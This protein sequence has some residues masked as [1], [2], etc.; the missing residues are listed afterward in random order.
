M[1]QCGV[2][3]P[4]DWSVWLS[5]GPRS[6][7]G[8]QHR[9]RLPPRASA[10]VVCAFCAIR[11]RDLCSLRYRPEGDA[12]CRRHHSIGASYAQVELTQQRISTEP[13]EGAAPHHLPFG[14]D[15]MTVGNAAQGGDMLI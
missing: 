6:A 13:L 5:R 1:S 14:N 9:D 10:T 2:S 8:A 7:D 3:V 12:G 4:V 11:Q 15:V